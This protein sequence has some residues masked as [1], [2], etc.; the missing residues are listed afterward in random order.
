[1]LIPHRRRNRRSFRVGVFVFVFVPVKFGLSQSFTG[2]TLQLKVLGYLLLEGGVGAEHDAVTLDHGRG[3]E[4]QGTHA[5][6]IVAL[7]LK[8]DL[9]AAEG[10][11]H[12][13]LTFGEGLG[14]V[15]LH[16]LEHGVAVGLGHGGAV[17]DALGELVHGELTG[18]D[19]GSVE[20]VYFGVLG[21]AY[22]LYCVGD[23]H[24]SLN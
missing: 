6:G 10:V 18:L 24:N 3:R 20:V 15:L 13:D 19:G 5:C 22:F 11:E 21:I 23:G 9:E 1:M 7:A 14:D 12:H 16:A 8:G 4:V 2:D 17:V